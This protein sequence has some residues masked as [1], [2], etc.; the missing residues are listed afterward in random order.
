MSNNHILQRNV[1]EGSE[2]VLSADTNPYRYLAHAAGTTLCYTKENA[3]L[4][5]ERQGS[6]DNNYKFSNSYH[7]ENYHSHTVRDKTVQMFVKVGL[8][9]E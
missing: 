4:Y 5:F 6:N 7:E 1:T 2:L 8:F 9:L 3:V